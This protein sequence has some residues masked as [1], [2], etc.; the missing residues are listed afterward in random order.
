[1]VDSA[2]DMTY[3]VGAPLP[4]IRGSRVL[5]IT[6]NPKNIVIFVKPA[7]PQQRIEE[8]KEG[9]AEIPPDSDRRKSAASMNKIDDRDMCDADSA[10]IDSCDAVDELCGDVEDSPID[11]VEKLLMRAMREYARKIK[12]GRR[13]TM[14]PYRSYNAPY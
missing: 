8:E 10:L 2:L 7:D 1:M 5:K 12:A 11:L 14:S 6:S 13:C 9:P 3:K 4:P